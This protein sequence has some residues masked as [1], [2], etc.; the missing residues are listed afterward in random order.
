MAESSLQE[1]LRMMA[2]P[3]IPA[4]TDHLGYWMRQVSNHVSQSFA[5]KLAGKGVTTA[6]WVLMRVLYDVD[7]LAPSRIAD[8]LGMTRGAISKLADRLIDKKMLTRAENP[9]DQ[10]AHTLSL[11]RRGRDLV[12]E[13]AQLADENDAALFRDLTD[14]ERSRMEAILRKIAESHGLRHVPVD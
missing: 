1:S 9:E 7:G 6:E 8:Q 13:L 4:L 12:P 5:R 11:S 2:P 14:T 3:K 10:R